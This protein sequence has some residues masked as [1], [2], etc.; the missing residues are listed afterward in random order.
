MRRAEYANKSSAIASKVTLRIA[1]AIALLKNATIKQKRSNYIMKC[2]T[3]T[4][5]K[6]NYQLSKNELPVEKIYEHLLANINGSGS[7]VSKIDVVLM[8]LEGMER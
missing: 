4:N 5:N 3:K 2:N 7:I 1:D 6:S 8:K